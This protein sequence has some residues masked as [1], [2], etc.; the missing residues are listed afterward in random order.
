VAANPG[1][2]TGPGT[3]EGLLRPPDVGVGLDG[4]QARRLMRAGAALGAQRVAGDPVLGKPAGVPGQP[5]RWCVP[6][7]GWRRWRLRDRG[8]MGRQQAQCVVARVDERERQPVA[9][10]LAHGG[11]IDIVSGGFLHAASCVQ[12]PIIGGAARRSD[13]KLRA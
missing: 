6:G 2:P 5:H 8:F 9:P 3:W 1:K 10:C 13:E 11:R 7:C 4:R 12:N